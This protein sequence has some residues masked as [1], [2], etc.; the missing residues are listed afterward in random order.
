MN[1]FCLL[2]NQDPLLDKLSACLST[3]LGGVRVEFFF[4]LKRL[5]SKLSDPSCFAQTVLMVVAD[6][7][8]LDDMLEQQELLAA[9]PL[10]LLVDADVEGNLAKGHLLRPRFIT[11]YHCEPE[12]VLE[13][14]R[15]LVRLQIQKNPPV[16]I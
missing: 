7:Q 15:N 5:L 11:G 14:L 10:V 3:A 16:A 1:L 13:V 12:T 2:Q 9:F 4:T 6:Q 8:I